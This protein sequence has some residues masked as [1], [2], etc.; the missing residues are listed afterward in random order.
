MKEIRT[1]DQKTVLFT[2]LFLGERPFTCAICQKG[3]NQKGALNLHMASHTGEKPH[4]CEFCPMTFSQKGNLRAHI[5]VTYLLLNYTNS[6][7]NRGELYY[8]SHAIL[9]FKFFTM[10]GFVMIKNLVVKVDDC[11]FSVCVYE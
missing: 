6:D 2:V 5:Q 10:L 4:Q 3:F 8:I 1:V 11:D 7:N 9:G